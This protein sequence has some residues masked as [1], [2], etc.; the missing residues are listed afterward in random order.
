MSLLLAVWCRQLPTS[1]DD[2]WPHLISQERTR[3]CDKAPAEDRLH[4]RMLEERARPACW[5][6]QLVG[7]AVHRGRQGA[8]AVASR[9]RTAAR[10]GQWRRITLVMPLLAIQSIPNGE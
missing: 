7:H 8:N 6:A 9:G 2:V 3:S 5:M 1:E 10:S 4:Q